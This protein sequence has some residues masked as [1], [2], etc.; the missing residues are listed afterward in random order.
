M[1]HTDDTIAALA[2]AP[3]EAGLAVVRVSGPRALPVADAVFRGRAPL[4]AAATHTLHHGWAVE[5]G[6]ERLDECK[7]SDL[8]LVAQGV[9]SLR[10]LHPLIDPLLY[11]A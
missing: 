3:G 7:I 1:L 6:S 8:F 5:P 10:S 9:D 2:T 11:P 4:A